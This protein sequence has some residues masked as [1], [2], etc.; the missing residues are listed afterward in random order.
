[1]EDMKSYLITYDE[2]DAISEFRCWVGEMNLCKLVFFS[3]SG[4]FEITSIQR[5]TI[6]CFAYV[7]HFDHK[8]VWSLTLHK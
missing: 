7:M 3:F 2:E 5:I 6:K 4:L 8:S 1:M